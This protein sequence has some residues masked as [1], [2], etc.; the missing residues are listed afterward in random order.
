MGG[1]ELDFLPGVR[2]TRMS[3]IILVT[4]IIS[5]V[6]IC[7]GHSNVTSRLVGEGLLLLMMV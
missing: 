3:V 1:R 5:G 4:F 6:I 7:R 2:V